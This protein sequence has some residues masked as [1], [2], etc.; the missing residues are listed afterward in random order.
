[1]G[2]LI[3]T[4]ILIQVEKG[5][6]N[7]D[8]NIAGR[9]QVDFFISVIT[10]SELLHG[11][12]RAKNAD[13]RARRAAFVEGV[14]LNFPI[15]GIDLSVAR[16]HSQLWAE[17]QQQGNMIGIHDTWI[18]AICMAF[19]LKLITRNLRDFNRVAGLLVECWQ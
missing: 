2:V 12:W 14:L 11:V 7:L 8:E 17:L 10:A 18:A 4:D 9:E 3:D 19:G 1:M 15:L 16:A 5:S 13:V 6:L